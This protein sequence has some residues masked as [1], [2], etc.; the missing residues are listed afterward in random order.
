[1]CSAMLLLLSLFPLPPTPH[2]SCCYNFP[3]LCS[4]YLT[5]AS[6][7]FLHLLVF[8]PSLYSLLPFSTPLGTFLKSSSFLP[9]TFHLPHYLLPRFPFRRRLL[10][11]LFSFSSSCFHFPF[12]FSLLILC[13]LFPFPFIHLLLP[14]SIIFSFFYLLLAFV[15]HFLHHLLAFYFLFLRFLTPLPLRFIPFILYSPSSLLFT[16]PSLY[17]IPS[18]LF[19]TSTLF[20]PLFHLSSFVFLPFLHPPFPSLCLCLLTDCFLLLLLSPAS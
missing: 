2:S 8:F 13:L 4:Y 17:F 16:Y 5:P 9:I 1:M 14:L 3:S 6:L 19:Y 10:A 7:F 20:P 12:L 18:S 15:L 11:Y